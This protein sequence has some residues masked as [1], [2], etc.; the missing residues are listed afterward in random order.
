MSLLVLTYGEIP[1]KIMQ[2]VF[3][4]TDVR[5]PWLPHIR[6]NEKIIRRLHGE[7]IELWICWKVVATGAI[8]VEVT[9]WKSVSRC[10]LECCSVHWHPH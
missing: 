6:D 9:V 10:K 3:N 4:L 7:L 1:L 5:H 8:N 2:M